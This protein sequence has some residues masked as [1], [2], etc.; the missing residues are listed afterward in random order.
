[1]AIILTS[2]SRPDL[3]DGRVRE[4]KGVFTNDATA[5]IS[6]TITGGGALGARS[7]TVAS[8]AIFTVGAPVSIAGGGNAGGTIPLE[9]RV[10]VLTD[11]TS[12]AVVEPVLQ[13]AGLTVGAAIQQMLRF[14]M[15]LAARF[16]ELE[17]LT[18]GITW[19]WY[20]GMAEHSAIRQVWA[21]GVTTLV[22]SGGPIVDGN[23]VWLPQSLM[24]VSKTFAFRA[25]A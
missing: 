11:A 20:D 21:S 17:N 3:A 19:R 5:L 6:A 4:Y 10:R 1:M 24:G 12:M 9:S 18:D 13:A 2:A 25:E 14:S 23:G 7:F 16:L 8:T 22:T 15:P